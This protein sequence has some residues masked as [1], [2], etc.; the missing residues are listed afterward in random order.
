MVYSNS[1]LHVQV[2]A[3]A[4]LRV[5]VAV[6]ADGCAYRLETPHCVSSLVSTVECNAAVAD[7]RKYANYFSFLGIRSP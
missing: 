1:Y 2:S 7:R 3:K 6:S 5:C 4:S